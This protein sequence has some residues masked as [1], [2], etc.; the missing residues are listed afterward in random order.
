MLAFERPD[1][2]RQMIRLAAAQLEDGVAHGRD[3]L[4]QNPEGATRAVLVVDGYVTLESGKTD[5]LIVEGV[6]YVPSR[7]SMTMAV[8]YR[9]VEAPGGFTV[10]R[11]KFMEVEGVEPDFSQLGEAFFVGVDGHEKGADVW[12][13]HIDQSL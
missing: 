1:G 5:A 8:P 13:R 2:S 3:W 11:P 7:A 4:A 9:S 6:R 12:N 10:F